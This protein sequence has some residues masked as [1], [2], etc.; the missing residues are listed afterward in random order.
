VSF[1]DGLCTAFVDMR[2]RG[3]EM[4]ADYIALLVVAF[5]GGGFG[6]FTLR[7]AKRYR[8]KLHDSQK[9]TERFK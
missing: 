8:N 2:F 9:K 5:V 3:I 4:S 7:E 6:L 1:I